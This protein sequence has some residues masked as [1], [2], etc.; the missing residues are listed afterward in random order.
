MKLFFLLIIF[1]NT[2]DV[3][4]DFEYSGWRYQDAALGS[5]IV[6]YTV[7]HTKEDLN[8]VKYVVLIME[9]ERELYLTLSENYKNCRLESK[10]EKH[11]FQV[12]EDI[13]IRNG[14][15]MMNKHLF[16]DS[17]DKYYY[18]RIAYKQELKDKLDNEITN[19]ISTFSVN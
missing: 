7:S 8:D 18:V 10:N 2:G 4:F 12:C 15:K 5:K 9:T 13:E 6:S 16:I 19:V 3:S 17:K 11:I 1:L 14:T